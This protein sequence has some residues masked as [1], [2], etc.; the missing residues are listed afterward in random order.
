MTLAMDHD[1]RVALAFTIAVFAA[2]ACGITIGVV[3]GIR[4]DQRRHRATARLAASWGWLFYENDIGDLPAQY[5]DFFSF[6]QIG[7]GR[8]AANI[9]V[10]PD[11][12]PAVTLFDYEYTTGSGKSAHT[13]FFQVA[14]VELPFAAPR[15]MIRNETFLDTLASWVGH[16]DLHFESEV[17]N[18]L[19]HVKCEE[20][21]FAYDIL[22]QRLLLYLMHQPELPHIEMRLTRMLLFFRNRGEIGRFRKL[23]DIGQEIIRSIPDYVL[24]ERGT[25]AA[26][27][28]R[29]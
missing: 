1:E 11:D 27:G 18:R 16:E 29:A 19:Y 21:R 5:H 25:G 10:S 8:S 13:S 22:H 6:F 24:H 17:F 26:G 9:M 2:M 28:R 7:H 12:W 14:V 20:P 15:L 4:R 23:L 3:L